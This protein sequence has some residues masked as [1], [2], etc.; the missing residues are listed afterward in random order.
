MAKALELASQASMRVI[1][2]KNE[3]VNSKEFERIMITILGRVSK[4][5]GL[6]YK[7]MLKSER[8]V[9]VYAQARPP[10]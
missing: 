3:A 10:G 6:A 2:R 8:V 9:S 1:D 5:K 7:Y 4:W